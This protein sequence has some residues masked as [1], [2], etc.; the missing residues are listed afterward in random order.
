MCCESPNGS[1]LELQLNLTLHLHF[2]LTQIAMRQAAPDKD[3]ELTTWIKAI[4]S[5]YIELAQSFMHFY[6]YRVAW[7]FQLSFI[8]F[9]P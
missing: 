3:F 7:L 5:F 6:S 1:Y 9:V 8:H 2:G 4:C